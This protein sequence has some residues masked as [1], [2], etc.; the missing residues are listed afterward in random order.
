M[1][2]ILN[3]YG[4]EFSDVDAAWPLYHIF[5]HTNPRILYPRMEFQ[6]RL[7]P[8]H[9]RLPQ[10]HVRTMESRRDQRLTLSP[11]IC[12]LLSAYPITNVHSIERGRWTTGME[13]RHKYGF[14]T[15][16]EEIRQ[17]YNLFGSYTWWK[18]YP[19][20]YMLLSILFF[21]I[22]LIYNRSY[23]SVSI[24]NTFTNNLFVI[25]KGYGKLTEHGN[26]TRS[27]ETIDVGGRCS[28]WWEWINLHKAHQTHQSPLLHIITVLT[29]T[30]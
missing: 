26:Q 25:I 23:L 16:Y 28:V 4:I 1:P 13:R 29:D 19:I 5:L 21:S 27:I 15:R 3:S 20:F 7:L 6:S 30:K 14:I 10:T 9:V 12:Y 22:L 8:M 17:V 2:R 11:L 18:I 24:S